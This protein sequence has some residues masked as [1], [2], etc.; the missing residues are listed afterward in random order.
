MDYSRLAVVGLL[1]LSTFTACHKA[2]P[3]TQTPAPIPV[4][5]PAPVEQVRATPT[6]VNR[7]PTPT[8][9]PTKPQP[10]QSA[11]L[12]PQ[13]RETLNA[14]L[15]RLEDALFDYDRASIRPDA[16]NALRSDVEV[17]RGILS[18]YPA[19]KL[20]IEGHADNRGSAEY[21]LALGDKRAVST[22][23]FLDQLGV[24]KTQL[25]VISFG[26]D[27]PVCNQ[28]TEECWQRNRRVHIT[29]AP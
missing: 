2:V 11:K 22:E 13:E 14:S 16:M 5:T 23:E 25:S 6:V 18:N 3:I 10:T 28:E 12:T 26:K 29:A 1:S 17:I 20:V 7:T 24:P 4:A 9:T 21:N 27:R 8:A 19:Q 15:A